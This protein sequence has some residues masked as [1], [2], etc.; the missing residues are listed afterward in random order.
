MK[1]KGKSMNLTELSLCSASSADLKFGLNCSIG[2][3]DIGCD[4]GQQVRFSQFSNQQTMMNN[5]MKTKGKKMKLMG[6][7]LCSVSSADL[8]FDLNCSIGRGDKV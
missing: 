1:T 4:G 3:G 7:R 2:C 8:K 6:L 5:S